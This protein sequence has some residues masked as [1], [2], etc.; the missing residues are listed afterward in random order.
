MAG[1]TDITNTLPPDGRRGGRKQPH[2]AAAQPAAPAVPTPTEAPPAQPQQQQQPAAA[3]EDLELEQ[4]D[5][6]LRSFR[7]LSFEAQPAAGE[8]AGEQQPPLA[9]EDSAA[10]SATGTSSQLGSPLAAFAAAKARLERSNSD[11]DSLIS[12]WRRQPAPD[13]ATPAGAPAAARA[14]LLARLPTQA[15]PRATSALAGGATAAAATALLRQRNLLPQHQRQHSLL[16]RERLASTMQL[17]QTLHEQVGGRA[18]GLREAA[19]EGDAAR[20]CNALSL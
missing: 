14:R 6:F 16:L 10:S 9:G 2:K 15:A 1:L 20:V 3:Q 19:A 5:E 12:A 17:C 8:A 4:V 7:K 13:A 18:V 11:A